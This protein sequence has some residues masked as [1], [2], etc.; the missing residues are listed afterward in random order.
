MVF[1]TASIE[2]TYGVIPKDVELEILVQSLRQVADGQRL[3]PLPSSDQTSSREQKNIAVLDN[4][5][6]VLTDRE[7]QIIPPQ[8][9]FDR[10]SSAKFSRAWPRRRGGGVVAHSS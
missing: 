4:A 8:G 5:L 3:L 1:F 2:G 9:S 10:A 7:Q 6:K